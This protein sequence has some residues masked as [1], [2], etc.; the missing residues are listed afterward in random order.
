MTI[1]ADTGAPARTGVRGPY[2]KTPLVRRRILMAALDLFAAAGFRTTTMKD[3]AAKAEISE[4]GLVHH[5][6]N[7][8]VLLAAALEMAE[9]DLGDELPAVRGLA[10]LRLIADSMAHSRIPVTMELQPILSAEATDPGHPANP[11]FTDRY[12]RARVSF[13]DM[14]ED[15]R[16]AGEIESPLDSDALAAMY[17]GLS[18]GLQKQWL[19][20]R[21]AVD[22][23]TV[24]QL[25]LDQLATPGAPP[26]PPRD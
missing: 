12:A 6:A 19:Y 26:A 24:L 8:E 7:K 15:A 3:I 5:F 22:P 14:F 25:F 13:A 1:D 18:D 10:A 23:A 9:S 21:S 17:I 20:D 4:R 11:Y 16:Q 2:A